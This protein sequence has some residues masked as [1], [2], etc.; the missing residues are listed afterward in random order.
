MHNSGGATLT[1]PPDPGHHAFM[2]LHWHHGTH[3][4]VGVTDCCQIYLRVTT[5]ADLQDCPMTVSA[6][7]NGCHL[8]TASRCR[9]EHSHHP[10]RPTQ[11]LTKPKSQ[12]S[13]NHSLTYLHGHQLPMASTWALCH[14]T[15][16]D[17]EWALWTLSEPAQLLLPMM[18]PSSE[19]LLAPQT[20]VIFDTWGNLTQPI[21]TS[22]LVKPQNHSAVKLQAYMGTIVLVVHEIAQ[23]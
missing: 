22:L 12:P 15:W 20:G 7:I 2:H 16:S 23:S 18:A 8:N 17:N 19:M 1:T 3:P 5:L 11:S 14:I 6:I 13:P 4:L 9:T 21:A 10:H